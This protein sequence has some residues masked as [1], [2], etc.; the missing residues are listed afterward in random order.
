MAKVRDTARPPPSPWAS[1]GM[2]QPSTQEMLDAAAMATM[3]MPV[4]GDVAGLASDAYR[5][6][7]D[8]E[9]RTLGNA[10]WASLGLLPFVPAMGAMTRQM[11][12]SKETAASIR[13]WA[14]EMGLSVSHK[15]SGI[16]GSQYLAIEKVD[17][18]GNAIERKMRI[19]DHDLPPSYQQFHGAA[20]YEI[21][22]HSMGGG[23]GA[24]DAVMW[25]S[26]Q[27]GA[28]IPGGMAGA[29]AKRRKQLADLASAK[30]AEST[31]AFAAQAKLISDVDKV[32][33]AAG[34]GA[35]LGE[36]IRQAMAIARNDRRNVAIDRIA[37]E[38]GVARQA[39]KDWHYRQPK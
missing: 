12:K 27:F 32:G 31:A 5:F 9:S 25:L 37:D 3:M 4:A 23:D 6:A 33:E 22:P 36:R 19:S 15:R 18:A 34:A 8:P 26:D 2:A 1:L 39:V 10:A 30:E 35:D 13:R 21:G 28:P 7:T 29:V 38:L 14:E 20:D 17:D 16:S 24:T 11:G